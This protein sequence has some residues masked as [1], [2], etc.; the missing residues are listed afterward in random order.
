MANFRILYLAENKGEAFRAKAPGK[1]PYTLKRSH[2]E[3]GPEVSAESPYALWERLRDPTDAHVAGFPRPF[4]IGDA[5]ETGDGLLICNYW[6]F[7]PAEWRDASH[8]DGSEG[9][10]VE[11]GGARANA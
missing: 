10:A 8:P 4:G 2:Y 7:D 11:T 1:P 6:G 3:D 5:L 9:E